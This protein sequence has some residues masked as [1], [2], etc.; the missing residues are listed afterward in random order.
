MQDFEMTLTGLPK[1]SKGKREQLRDWHSARKRGEKLKD[2][3][4]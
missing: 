2:S 4:D 3:S 1:K